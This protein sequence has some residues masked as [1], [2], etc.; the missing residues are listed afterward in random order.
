MDLKNKKIL[1]IEDD[2]VI[3]EMYLTKFSE[4]GINI[5]TAQDGEAGL[6]LAQK[7]LP[8]VVL[9]DIIMPKMDGFAVLKELS[10][11][12]KTKKIPVI[13]LTNLGQKSDIEKG[14]TLGAK[15]YIVK[16]TMTPT[17]MLDKIKEIITN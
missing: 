11:N 4:D 2:L 9:L 15:D 14:K 16:A 3:S 6:A 10:G 8:D 1:L 7:E 13:L 12:P 17:Q 5:L